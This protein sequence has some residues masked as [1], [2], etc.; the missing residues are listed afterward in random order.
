MSRIYISYRRADGAAYAGRLFDHLNQHF[1]PDFVFMD[2]QG[3]IAR[4]QDFTKAIDTALNTCDVALVIIGKQ[5]ATSAGSD[6][7]LRLDDPNDWVRVEIAAVLRRDILVVPVLVDGAR[8]PEPASLPEELRPLCRRN[9]CELTDS[10]WSYDVGELAK[11]IDKILRPPKGIKIPS[12]DIEKILR[13]ARRIKA[14]QFDINKTLRQVKQIKI[15]N[16]RHNTLHWSV[17]AVTVLVVLLGIGILGSN[18]SWFKQ[19]NPGSKT[20]PAKRALEPI[21][22]KH[23]D[24]TAIDAPNP[25][26]GATKPTAGPAPLTKV[27]QGGLSTQETRAAGVVAALARFVYAESLITAEVAFKNTG[28]EPVK[29]CIEGW[30]L[31]DEK[32][33]D[34]TRSYV[35]G[36]DVSCSDVKSLAPRATHI[37]WAKFKSAASSN[38]KYSLDIEKI[39]IR[40]F[41]ELVPE[42]NQG[43]LSTQETRVPDVVV[44][45]ARFVRAEN[46]VTAEVAFKNTGSE[47]VK[48]CLEGWILIDEKTGDKTRSY[49]TGGDVSCSDVKSLTPRATHVAWAKFKSDASSNSKYSLDIEKILIRPFEELVTEFN[50]G[51]LSTQETRVPGVVVELARFVRAENLVTAEAAFKNTGS[52]PVKF[53]LEGWILIDEKTGD[54]TRSDVTGG[55]VSC[56][57]VKSLAPRA[58]HVAWAK[59][60]S[61]ASSNSKYSLDI[62][63]ILIRPFEE[64]VTE[65]AQGDHSA[66]E[67]RVAGVVAALARFVRAENLITTEVAFKNTG[68]EP[69]K[70]CFRSWKLID[71]KTG[72]TSSSSVT[73]GDVSC[74][75]VKSLPQGATH[76]AW[77]K[78]K[79]DTSSTSNYS[80]DIEGILNRP[81]EGLVLTWS[82]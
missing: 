61:D 33:G 62:E 17:G 54:R 60:K 47:P 79:S 10:R 27:T 66:Q 52:E 9:V 45:L 23:R 31:I 67:T 8:L 22:P 18:V 58:T 28:S 32:T 73:G 20:T 3:S 12:L 1:G 74:S 80:L 71:E 68:S 70:F 19:S 11:D 36:G 50:Q 44:E 24:Q 25:T 2:V 53:C 39:L 16:L 7:K 15:G 76:V 57:D 55:D 42:F 75:D 82:K 35:T 41:E 63:K 48:F 78:F 38:S 6:G 49:V 56:S 59:F 14:L 81:F 37:A 30:I 21:N 72:K 29:F 34:Q 40:P 65:F 5:W 4:G 26:P 69:A 77:A 43:G 46:L 64:L 51:G 13:P